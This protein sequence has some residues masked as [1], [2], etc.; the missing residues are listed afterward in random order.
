MKINT[1]ELSHGRMVKGSSA[2]RKEGTEFY[3]YATR[4]AY[5][6]YFSDSRPCLF[7]NPIKYSATTSKQMTFLKRYY[8]NRG[9]HIVNWTTGEVLG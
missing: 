7:C 5:I 1:S 4:I 3:S 2:L 6:D 8:R 9:F